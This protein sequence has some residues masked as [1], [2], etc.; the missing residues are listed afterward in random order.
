MSQQ[1]S[2]IINIA[3]VCCSCMHFCMCL[4]EYLC[5][6]ERTGEIQ[7][8][9]VCWFLCVCVCV[10]ERERERERSSLRAQWISWHPAVIS[11]PS[12]SLSFTHWMGSR[13]GSWPP[14]P[15]RPCQTHATF[16]IITQ[17]GR[18]GE[19]RAGEKKGKRQRRGWEGRHCG[20]WTICTEWV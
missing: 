3:C 11:I 13:P 5:V 7:C 15:Q 18:G 20:P 10:W 1:N 6:W 2:V 12:L 17:Q 14:L 19:W 4:W 16:S 9:Y 8:L